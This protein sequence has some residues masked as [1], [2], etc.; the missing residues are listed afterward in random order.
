M[1]PEQPDSVPLL[2]VDLAT[3]G[4]DTV[5]FIRVPKLNMRINRNESGMVTMESE[6]NPLPQ[7]DEWTILPDG[8]IAV[9]RGSDY[10]VEYFSADGARTSARVPFEWQR[11]SDEDKVTFMDSVKVAFER[12]MAAGELAVPGM[13]MGGGAQRITI[14]Q[15]GPGGSGGPGGRG[16]GGG[17]APGMPQPRFNFIPPEQLPDYRPP[18][19][20]GA[21]R[22]D[23]DGN[24]WVA[25]TRAA[26]GRPVYDVIDRNGQLIDRVQVPEGRAIV[27]FAPGAVYLS[28]RDGDQARLER[29]ALR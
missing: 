1:P 13:A 19:F 26:G 27:G 6:I 15:G 10:R 14:Q 23:T 3:R 12:R 17:A 28:S 25:T 8:S 7:V 9:V 24:L 21:L 4:L 20:A 16:A 5:T 2:R 29:A 11:L 18:F 22:A